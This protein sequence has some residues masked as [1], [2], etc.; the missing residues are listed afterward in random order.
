MV[1]F[2]KNNPLTGSL[3]ICIGL[4]LANIFMLPGALQWLSIG[5]IYSN[6]YTTVPQIM[7]RAL[8][9]AF[10]GIQIG[11][12]LAFLL[13]R[14]LFRQCVLSYVEKHKI[15]RAIDR[16]MSK[17]GIK[18]SILIRLA[19]IFPYNI[20]NYVVGVTSLKLLDFF[21]G[22]VGII[23]EVCFGLYIGSSLSNSNSLFSS[24]FT[25]IGIII[26]IIFLIYMGMMAK[27]EMDK[28][29]KDDE[30]DIEAAQFSP[31]TSY[32]Q[33]DLVFDSPFERLT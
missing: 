29:L 17:K 1:V 28:E 13:S 6:A 22:N 12:S 20:S 3:V 10:I 25:I 21:I 24:L 7:L 9:V 32:I 27:K 2:V 19:P 16:M 30:D 11:S 23:P 15:V 31:S 26:G 14:Y 18:I 4:I 33:R 8:P 5:Y